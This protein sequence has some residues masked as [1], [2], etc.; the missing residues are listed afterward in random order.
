MVLAEA[1]A[2]RVPERGIE[3]MRNLVVKSMDE[4]KHAGVTE[5]QYES[6]RKEMIERK[7]VEDERSE[8]METCLV[9]MRYQQS[10]KDNEISEPDCMKNGCSRSCSIRIEATHEQ[11]IRF[12]HCLNVDSGKPIDLGEEV[13]KMLREV[14]RES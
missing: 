7:R 2:L 8:A 11:R 12:L 10:R 9:W 14:D 3:I 13:R 4:L 6:L 1:K 5:E